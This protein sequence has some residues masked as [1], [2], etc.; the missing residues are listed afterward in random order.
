[1]RILP[2]GF[3][4]ILHLAHAGYALLWIFLEHALDQ[5]NQGLRRFRGKACQVGNGLCK[6]RHNRGGEVGCAERPLPG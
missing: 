5:V 1:M 6:N 2:D 4:L 3:Q